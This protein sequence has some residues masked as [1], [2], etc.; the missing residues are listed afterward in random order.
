MSG[1]PAVLP[2]TAPRRT[3]P[4]AGIAWALPFR[5]ALRDMPGLVAALPLL[6]PPSRAQRRERALER[7]LDAM[8]ARVAEAE[9]ALLR[10]ERRR[11]HEARRAEAA[12]AAL[13]RLQDMLDQLR[14]EQRAATDSPAV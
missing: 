3:A 2:R 10:E 11:L 8:A 5:Q 6:R 12:E 1:L 7:T 14:R 4:P 9:L 13:V